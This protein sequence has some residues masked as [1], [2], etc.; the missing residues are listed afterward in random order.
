LHAKN[1]LYTPNYAL[2]KEIADMKLPAVLV[3]E[4]RFWTPESVV[5]AMRIGADAVVIGK[6]ITNPMAITK[7]F[8]SRIGELL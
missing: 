6:A 5:E 4:G 1:E 2:I 3:A 7:Y 8:V